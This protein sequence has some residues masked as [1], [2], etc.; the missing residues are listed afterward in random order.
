MAA[1]AIAIV[2]VGLL[3]ALG[4]QGSRI[5]VWS[6]GVAAVVIGAASI[7]LPDAPG[8]ISQAWGSLVVTWEILFIKAGEW[9]DRGQ[10]STAA[11]Y[12]NAKETDCTK[13]QGIEIRGEGKLL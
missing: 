3:A 6:A 2:V 11:N 4:T 1:A 7:V 13:K 9:Q 10:P 8:A 12:L 5:A